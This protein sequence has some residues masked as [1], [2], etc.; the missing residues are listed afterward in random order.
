[1]LIFKLGE[2]GYNILFDN[3]EHFTTYCRNGVKRSEQAFAAKTV[4]LTSVLAVGMNPGTAL[5][6]TA[7]VYIEMLN[8]D[9]VSLRPLFGALLDGTFDK[10]LS[11]FDNSLLSPFLPRLLASFV[12]VAKN[13]DNVE[14]LKSLL[15]RL[16]VLDGANRVLDLASVDFAN[17]P[18][19]PFKNP[20]ETAEDKLKSVYRQLEA[21][22]NMDTFA[23]PSSEDVSELEI[24][25]PLLRMHFPSIIPDNKLVAVLLNSEIGVDLLIHILLNVPGMLNSIISSALELQQHDESLRGRNRF[26]LLKNILILCPKKVIPVLKMLSEN[27]RDAALSIRLATECLDDDALVKLVCPLI[28]DKSSLIG[29]QVQ[30]ARPSM[31]LL[32]NRIYDIIENKLSRNSPEPLTD[33]LFVAI[34]L[35][36]VSG[37]KFSTK[38]NQLLLDLCT[39]T[40]E[41]SDAHKTM[42]FA[43]IL[44]IPSITYHPSNVINVPTDQKVIEFLKMARKIT[45]P[46]EPIK[47]DDMEI[48]TA[49]V[50]PNHAPFAHAL[51]YIH[52]CLVAAKTQLLIE[53]LSQ[54][55]KCKV[56]IVPRHVNVLRI[57]LQTHCLSDTELGKRCALQPITRQ[58]SEASGS[59][60]PVNIIEELLQCKF[61]DHH[62]VNIA[63]WLENQ[64]REVTIPINK[65]VTDL[66]ERYAFEATTSKTMGLGSDFVENTFGDDIMNEEKLPL[67]L[68]VMLYLVAYRANWERWGKSE[69]RMYTH[70]M[71]SKMPIRYMLSVVETRP[72]DFKNL[73]GALTRLCTDIFPFMLPTT[74]SVILARESQLSNKQPISEETIQKA[75]FELLLRKSRTIQLTFQVEGNNVAKRRKA[76]QFIELVSVADQVR[77]LNVIVGAYRKTLDEGTD[78]STIA[79]VQRLWLRLEHVVPRMLCE[80]SIL[81]WLDP[82]ARTEVRLEDIYEKPPLIFRCDRRIFSSPPHFECFTHLSTFFFTACR[83]QTFRDLQRCLSRDLGNEAERNDKEVLIMA[84]QH[85][86]ESL[87]VQ[88]LVEVADPKRMDKENKSETQAVTRREIARLAGQYI[89]QIFLT[90]RQVMKI[91]V[92]QTFPLHQ[93]GQLIEDV[94]SL[95]FASEFIIEM[96]NIADVKRRIFAVALLVQIAKKYRIPA[97]ALQSEYVMDVIDTLSQL[98][99]FGENLKLFETAAPYLAELTTIFPQFAGDISM[100][101]MRVSAIAKS[102]LAYKSAFS[103]PSSNA[104]ATIAEKITKNLTLQIN[105]ELPST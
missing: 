36:L 91:S 15:G 22:K 76:L 41:A 52:S 48:E 10:R 17:L 30:R 7:L 93:L 59:R 4:A 57:L 46:A 1:M 18:N 87:L 61:F 26:Q 39:R 64:L 42:C 6:V 31:Q 75:R 20:P 37:L 3:C 102:C 60:L 12:V 21:G 63:K 82:L 98:A 51:L 77:L 29:A 53:Y 95:Y 33:V 99:N 19:K 38:E 74:E 56:V 70:E 2:K 14:N 27:R 72:R 44:A 103:I 62:P 32:S 13:P 80:R 8:L 45:S 73:R 78:Q 49:E 86:M 85:T 88:L 9:L 97:T 23:F 105:A 35:N 79:I 67:R 92:F 81:A 25:L 55:L 71:Y 50:P 101:L 16:I 100:I 11:S 54:I 47:E 66:L 43:A 83:T 40:F 5:V 90:D 68:C 28:A 96:L 69:I 65:T 84:M 94:P 58:L 89:H 34:T 24:I 104:E